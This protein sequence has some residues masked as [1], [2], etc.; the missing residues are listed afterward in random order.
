MGWN[1]FAGHG[2]PPL[3]CIC[4]LTTEGCVMRG[5]FVFVLR[6]SRRNY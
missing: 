4:K 3:T 2:I 6:I 1:G 5:E